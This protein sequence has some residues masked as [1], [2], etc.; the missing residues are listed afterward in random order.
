MPG[1][2][3]SPAPASPVLAEHAHHRPHRESAVLAAAAR[4]AWMIMCD[5]DDAVVAAGHQLGQ[6]AWSCAARRARSSRTWPGQ[7]ASSASAMGSRP[8]APPALL[9]SREQSGICA[10][11]AST[12]AGSVTSRVRA[13]APSGSATA[14]SRSRRRAPTTTSNPSAASRVA[15][16]APMPELA[17]VMTATGLMGGGPPR[18]DR[19][20]CRSGRRPVRPPLPPPPTPAPRAPPRARARSPPLL[21]PAPPRG[22]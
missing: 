15:V 8:R 21:P 7:S 2:I 18:G 4:Y 13:R 17:P 6:Q 9:T 19:P 22:G 14:R 20:S 12:E 10:Q 11:N 16:A 1:S 3:W 5:G